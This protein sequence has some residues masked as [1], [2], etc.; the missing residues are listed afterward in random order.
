MEQQ[1]VI[2]TGQQSGPLA[3][4]VL[5]SRLGSLK[6]RLGAP[7]FNGVFQALDQRLNETTRFMLR[8]EW[9]KVFLILLVVLLLGMHAE[10]WWWRRRTG[11]P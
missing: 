11:R 6:A 7:D 10:R 5:Q 8:R 9:W 3:L 1:L 4:G 2:L